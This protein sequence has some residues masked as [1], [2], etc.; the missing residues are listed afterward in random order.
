MKRLLSPVVGALLFS[1]LLARPLFS[2]SQPQVVAPSFINEIKPLLA[3]RCY[4]CHGPDKAEGGLRF[5]EKKTVF[6]ELES[7]TVAIVA[8]DPDGSEVIRRISSSDENERMPPEGDPLTPQQI[9]V[10]K[11]WVSSGAQWQDHWAFVPRDNVQPP[12][13]AS[14]PGWAKNPIDAFILAGLEK[15]GLRPNPPAEKAVLIRRLYY[16]LTG[17][18]PSPE[19]VAAFVDDTNH[20]AYEA[21]VDKLLASERYGE[22]W[23]RHWLDVVRY[24][25]TNSYERDGEKPNSWKYRDYIIRSFNSDKPY[26]QFVREQLAGDEIGARDEYGQIDQD[27]LIATGFYRLGRWDDEPADKLQAEFDEWDDIVTVTGQAFLG[28]TVNCARC[29]DHKI[30]PIPQADYYQL[31]AC[32][33][34]IGGHGDGIRKTDQYCQVDVSPPELKAV[35]SA[36]DA[37][38]ETLNKRITAIEQAGIVK[39]SAE[40]QRKTEGP[41]RGEV[42]K[43]K[44]DQHL[45]SSEREE[46]ARLKRTRELSAN[47]RKA[48]PPRER[49][50][51]VTQCS[52]DPPETHILGRGNPHSAG[53]VVFPAAPQ[54]FGKVSF[55]SAA[56]PST[57]VSSGRRTALAH[58][59]ASADNLLT[60]R[61]MANRIWQ[62]HMGR[63]IV[64]SPNNF[65]QLGSPPT[66]PELLDWLANQ[67][68]AAGWRMKPIHKLIVMSNTYQ[69]SSAAQPEALAKDPTNDSYWRFDMRRLSA[70]E[71]RDSVHSVTGVLNTQMYGRGYFPDISEEVMSGQSVPGNGWEKSSEEEQARRSVYIFVKRSLITPILQDFDF[72][73][74]DG[75]CEARFATTQPA[76]AFGMLNSDFIHEQ[77]ERFS[78]RLKR[79]CGDDSRGQVLRALSLLY[80]VPPPESDVHRFLQLMH[81]FEIKHGKTKDESLKL[82]CLAA[83]NL[84]RFIYLD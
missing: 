56:K 82:F 77:A 69:M 32:F 49:V 40:D 43:Q 5:S 11:A 10:L 2:Q 15:K 38:E 29:H 53:D 37:Y 28:L 25:D 65:G 9:E 51:G 57:G 7:G 73:E 75:S 23:A 78:E 72:P 80:S 19:E 13:S 71:I 18:P 6:E 12:A 48:L 68:V 63:G 46:Y 35:Y 45:S 59:I 39:M 84:N 30:D 70:E 36:L 31:L 33:R 58:W 14:S 62:F 67:F 76:Q 42:L 47:S 22:H 21:L 26:D 20:G 64:R 54:L 50:L 60:A 52:V 66:H 8:G 4:A 79:E 83:L 34:D 74:T 16:D 3:K 44:L 81:D 27:A 24:A 61:V 17:L 1:A 55:A 41:E